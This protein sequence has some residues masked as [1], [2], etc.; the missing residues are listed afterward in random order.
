MDEYPSASLS[1]GGAGA[2]IR[3]IDPSDNRGAGAFLGNKCRKLAPGSKV[4]INVKK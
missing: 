3:A 2:I 4:K 1:E